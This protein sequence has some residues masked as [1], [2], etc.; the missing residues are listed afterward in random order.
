MTGT[1]RRIQRYYF[2]LDHLQLNTDQFFHEEAWREFLALGVPEK[3]WD[4]AYEAVQPLG[5]TLLK[6]VAEMHRQMS[7]KLPLDEMQRLLDD[8]FSDLRRFLFPDVVPTLEALKSRGEAVYLLSFGADEWQEW[9][10]KACGISHY[11]KQVFYTKREGRKDKVVYANSAPD[12]RVIVVDNN[13]TELDAIK[14][15]APW[16][17]TYYLSRV[18]EDP[19]ELAALPPR[20]FL[21]AKRYA[22][23]P[24]A[25]HQRIRSLQ[26]VLIL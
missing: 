4:A 5:Y 20:A 19:A 6:H 1:K 17:E 26:D 25:G 10:V 9:K 18:P 3:I 14:A 23:R 12:E 7:T 11:F 21:E 24:S 13:P 8:R 16:V 22:T 15:L 2:D